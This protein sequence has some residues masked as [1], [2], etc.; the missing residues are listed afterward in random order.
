MRMTHK[1][2]EKP[3]LV[4]FAVPPFF[5][6]IFT[7]TAT[8][9]AFI[10]PPKGWNTYKTVFFFSLFVLKRS[11][12]LRDSYLPGIYPHP[13]RV[14]EGGIGEYTSYYDWSERRETETEK[15]VRNFPYSTIALSLNIEQNK[16]L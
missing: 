8:S 3:Y 13:A 9:V 1:H 5:G 2:L 7:K 12:H 16:N 11:C 15:K 6:F 14:L 4:P 10:M